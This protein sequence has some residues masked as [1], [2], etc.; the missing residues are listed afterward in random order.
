MKFRIRGPSGVTTAT[1]PDTATIQVLREEILKTTSLQAFD[2]K[3]G[4]PPKPLLLDEYSRSAGLS[5]LGIQL[6]G[7][8]LIVSTKENPH[9]NQSQ[10]DPTSK[11]TQ[12]YPA[13]PI[14]NSDWD[15]NLPEKTQASAGR[16]GQSN[17][18]NSF[19]PLIQRSDDNDPPELAVPSHGGTLVLRI[20]PDDNSCLFRA[21]GSSFL[22][23]VDSM[24][25]LRSLI[26][27]NIQA[28]PDLYSEAVLEQKPDDYCRWIQTEDA[29]GGGIELSILS[30]HF[31]IEICSID[32]Q[33]LRVDRFNEG[34]P[35]RCIL[36][37]S[38]IHYDAIALS[39]SDPPYHRS[40]APPDFDT[41]V[42]DSA[43][44]IILSTAT[45][46]CRALQ[47]KHYFTDTASFAVRCNVCGGTFVGEKGATEHAKR[48]G[49]QD[50]GEAE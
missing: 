30:S 14:N 31:D 8:Q 23:S 26:A 2:L 50:F 18:S 4:Y 43:D 25:E 16:A 36:V 41:K 28:Q 21:F 46:L 35:L 6:H 20:M 44:S 42:F 10:S 47:Q 34:R 1:I 24:T 37:Y 22:G 15:I 32:V 33:T 17:A 27:Q 12:R 3:I 49:H 48:S 11:D 19:P 5:E 38:G 9:K 13:T 29:W 7:E 45:E 39:P 40:Y